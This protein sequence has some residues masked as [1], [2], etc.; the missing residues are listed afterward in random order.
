M[1]S[2][3]FFEFL[4]AYAYALLLSCG[5]NLP[6]EF[7]FESKAPKR[8]KT[9]DDKASILFV[10]DSVIELSICVGFSLILSCTLF[11][12]L[13]I[14]FYFSIFFS[15]ESREWKYCGVVCLTLCSSSA[16]GKFTKI[17]FNDNLWFFSCAMRF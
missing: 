1:F 5:I 13:I 12:S 17:E 8:R 11:R 9:F 3:L 2:L 15:F 4:F 10:F 7:M 6:D 14:Y 16:K